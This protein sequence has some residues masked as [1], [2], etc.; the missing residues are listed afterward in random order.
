MPVGASVAQGMQVEER[1]QWK[2]H[3]RVLHMANQSLVEQINVRDK[4]LQQKASSSPTNSPLVAMRPVL[5]E[6]TAGRSM[7]EAF[8]PP[9]VPRAMPSS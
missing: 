2:M 1:E 4:L 9:L 8:S 6:P 5:L 7:D 3:L